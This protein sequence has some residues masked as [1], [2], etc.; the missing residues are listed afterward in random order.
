[1]TKAQRL[2]VEQSEKRQRLNELLT[3]ETLT[4]EQRAEMDTLTKRAQQI[5]VEL[6]AALVVEGQEEAEARSLFGNGDG[7][8]GERGRLLEQTTII[9]YLAPASAGHGIEGRAAELNAALELPT[10]GAGGGVPVPWDM[11]ETRAFTTTTQND[12]SERQ[13]PILQR[14][15]GPGIMDTLGVRVDTVPVGRTEWPL[16][17]GGVSPAQAKEG[18]A[19][20]AAVPATFSFATLKPKRL[21]GQYEYTHEQAASVRD[22][23]Q[24]LRRDLAD[25][26]KASMS[27]QIVNGSAPTNQNPQH[28]EGFLTKLTATDLS[29]AEAAAADYGRLHSLG[30]D[31]IHASMETEVSSVVGDETYRHAAGVYISGSGE[32]RLRA[33]DAALRRLH[34]V[35]VHSRH[36]QHEAECDSPCWRTQRRADARGFGRRNVADAGDHP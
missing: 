18:T 35:D 17:S 3:A 7:E 16:I 22:L 8:A 9:D 34:G 11:I 12:G 5:E 10:V 15:F 29:S 31:G 26:V 27:D 19:A 13:R 30:V 20:S 28:V 2:Q 6:R 21:T 1:M 33:T 4:E 32:S 23:E 14:L 25:A 36:R 24:G